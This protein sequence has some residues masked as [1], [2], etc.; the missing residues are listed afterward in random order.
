VTSAT[1]LDYDPLSA[2]QGSY[3]SPGSDQLELKFRAPE[4]RRECVTRTRLI[5]ALERERTRPLVLL[6]AP[7]GYGKTTLLAQWSEASAR[8][9]AWLRLDEDD[10]ETGR[11][12]DLIDVALA[13]V[14]PLHEPNRGF[15]LVLDDSHLAGPEV[16]QEA[17]PELLGWMPD[18]SQLAL[19]SR[20]EPAV[21]LGRLRA[22]R[23][24]F[25]LGA[26]DLAV[27]AP[28]ASILL[29]QAG[30]DLD[31]ATVE[32]LVRRTGG[33]PVALEL[34]ALS[35]RRVESSRGPAGVISGDD[36]LISEYFRAEILSS[37]SPAAVRFL[38]RSSVLDRL[39]GPLCDAVLDRN[40][41]GA[42]LAELVLVNVPLAPLDSSHEWYRL[43][44]LLREMLQTELRR[45]EP[46]IRLAV[47]RRASAW[48]ERAGEVDHAID[49]A[50]SAEDLERVGALLW[51]NLPEYLGEGRNAS[52]QRW[53]S[54][55]TPKP[56]PAPLALVAAHSHLAA[57]HVAVAEQWAR[58][59]A[60]DLSGPSE[61]TTRSEQAALRIIDAWV[62]RSGAR[63]MGEAAT[64]AYDLLPEDSPWRANCCFL[65]G[66]AALLTGALDEAEG[67]FQEGVA[68]GAVV[69]V[70]A[71]ALCLA[72]LAV[73]AAE[74]NQPEA[75]SDFARRAHSMVIEHELSDYPTCALVAA[76]RAVDAIRERRADEAKAAAAQC[77][78]L[79]ESLDESM[80]WY[81]AEARILLAQVA[82]SLGDV[83]GARA[84]LA[85]ASRL[86]RR[87]P[88]GILYARW[89]DAAWNQFDACA[90]TALAGVAT[91]TTAELRVLRFLP[92][93]YS[94]HE[95]AE[96]L[97]VSSNTVKTHV[98]AV[99]RKL[100]AS[101]RS[102]AVEHAIQAGLLSS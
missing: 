30:V 36:H 72:Q 60:A 66:S 87:T 6:A 59:A 15:V 9:F 35:Y 50:R 25:E 67:L 75:A 49:H 77:L 14:G 61:D 37:L 80:C 41:S 97:H 96:R 8:P 83:P 89:F 74:R 56:S 95:I 38:A 64:R 71:A 57:G 34:A 13:G 1:T 48:Y 53:L 20:C 24:V 17:I 3:P 70:D 52:I 79:L 68:R 84:R 21:G 11:L 29:G 33:W 32:T 100:D 82:L 2:D 5:A 43:D 39:S 73:V 90:E 65:G 93:H 86:S 62:A 91:L 99:Y 44:P 23:L 28:E 58:C 92:T 7:A 54:G 51:A 19:A 63:E 85:D 10:R 4:L 16:L 27:S 78:G 102:Q 42:V 81:G 12:R 69:A 76:V 31:A 101:S 94:F 55:I 22:H 46:E 26:Q 45:T 47:H 18:G 98:H 40:R 88:D